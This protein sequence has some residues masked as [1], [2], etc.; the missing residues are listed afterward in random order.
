MTTFANAIVPLAVLVLLGLSASTV[1]G[2]AGARVVDPC[3]ALQVRNPDGNYIVPGVK[4]DIPYSGDLALD[5]YIQRGP[6]RR[7]SVIV[8]HGGAWSS[9]SRV[10]HVG[11]IL[12]V[13]T[14]AGYHWFSVDYRLGGVARFED[15]LADLRSAL[16]FVR[17]H[18]SAL[19]IDPTQLI[20]LGEDSGAHLAALLAAERPAGVVGAVLL[21]GF[22]DLRAIPTLA[23]DLDGEALARASPIAHV[24]PQMPP[25]LVVHGGADS[26][27][28]VEQARRYCSEVARSQGRCRFVEVTG[29]SHRSEN[30]WPSQWSYKREIVKWIGGARVRSGAGRSTARRRSKTSRKTSSTAGLRC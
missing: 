3:P 8:I 24:V 15:G 7:P 10:A 25:L 17:C 5:A 23:R 21:G 18:A 22:Y 28:P 6:G 26:D 20:L 13:L 29:A 12:E 27:T 30:W 11:Q 16:A 14:R 2:A 4:G 1:P 19:G 9:G